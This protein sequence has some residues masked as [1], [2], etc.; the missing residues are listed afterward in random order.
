MKVKTNFFRVEFDPDREWF[1]YDIQILPAVNRKIKGPDGEFT[2]DANGKFIKELVVKI[3]KDNTDKVINLERGSTPL[4][5]RILTK[6]HENLW[7]ESKIFV[8]S[9]SP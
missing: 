4:S 5:R 3:K 8:V 6:L 2:K 1:M 9:Q 7:N